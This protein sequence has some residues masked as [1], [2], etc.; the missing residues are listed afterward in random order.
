MIDMDYVL[1]DYLSPDQL[2]IDDLIGV[3]GEVVRILSISPLRYGYSVTF[4][5]E[6]GERDVVDFNDDEQINLYV[7]Q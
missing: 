6:F 5:N 1:V 4:E 7:M 2:E 3:E